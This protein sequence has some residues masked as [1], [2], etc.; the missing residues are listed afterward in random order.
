MKINLILLLLFI[1]VSCEKESSKTIDFDTFIITVPNNWKKVDLKGVDSYTG[2]I[3]LNN[4]DTL[5]FDYGNNTAVIND[6]ILVNDVKQ[7]SI[8]KKEGFTVENFI[9]SKTPKI[10]ENQG[11][12]HKEYYMYD[13]I[14]GYIPK[15]KI[16]KEIG[17]GLTAIC[18]DSINIKK[19]RLYLYAKDLDTL[20]QFQLLKAFKTIRIINTGN[21]PN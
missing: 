10:D 20:E 5:F 9:F 14:N 3:K 21:V 8:M 11:V 4:K 7:F 2:G 12:F 1:L 18:F 13:T 17:N 16:P 19:E 6:V 15:L